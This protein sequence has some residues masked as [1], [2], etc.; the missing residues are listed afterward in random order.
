MV[1]CFSRLR[2]GF[3]T[4][5]WFRKRKMPERTH[6]KEQSLSDFAVDK[7][8][9][10]GYN[11]L[12]YRG[13]P[14]AARAGLRELPALKGSALYR[15]VSERP[16]SCQGRCE[17]AAKGYGGGRP[18]AP[19][20]EYGVFRVKESERRFRRNLGGTTGFP[21]PWREGKPFLFAQRTAE[22]Q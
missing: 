12:V 22:K 3:G 16:L 13:F 10:S 18:G 5:F 7:R 4:P 11:F 6:V 8:N 17:R 20:E 21:V 19:C 9:I 14:G 15:F 1:L 2:M